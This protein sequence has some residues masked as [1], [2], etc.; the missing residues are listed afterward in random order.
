[1]VYIFFNTFLVRIFTQEPAVVVA[2]AQCLRIVSYGYLFYAWELVM[3]Q[4]FNGAGDTMTPTK[5]N[6]F[7][8]WLFEIP[9]AYLLA[10][11]WGAG[12]S[13]VYWAIV[14]TESIAGLVA[15]WLF[16]RGTWKTR[17]V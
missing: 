11:K 6:F 12:E 15:I 1:L 13:G 2:G 9:F 7:C 8:F 14:A 5:I 3:I 17:M 10:L 4:A 16:K